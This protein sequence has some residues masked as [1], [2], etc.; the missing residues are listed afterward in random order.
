MVLFRFVLLLFRFVMVMS[1]FVLGLFAFVL[2]TSPTDAP[3]A[4]RTP[5][6]AAS[7]SPSRLSTPR[8]TGGAT[9]GP[10]SVGKSGSD[11]N[12]A[13]VGSLLS[14]RV[15]QCLVQKP[16]GGARARLLGGFHPEVL[17]PNLAVIV[18]SHAEF[19]DLGVKLRLVSL[20]RAG[21]LALCSQ[22]TCIESP[23]SRMSR[24]EPVPNA[25]M[26]RLPFIS[27]PDVRHTWEMSARFLG[28]SLRCPESPL[29]LLTNRPRSSPAAQ[30]LAARPDSDPG[31]CPSPADYN[32]CNCC[33]SP[34][35][36]SEGLETLNPK[37]YGGC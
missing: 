14:L 8:Q 2:A 1:R 3:F 10:S 28:T 19:V 37:P 17:G 15:G 7:R 34:D 35:G 5:K 18:V 12:G 16:G 25:Q 33:F 29:G 23:G 6:H 36:I 13:P 30:G 20:Q 31:Q 22:T 21:G 11:R 26:Q 24:M 32:H 9:C 27:C 4:S